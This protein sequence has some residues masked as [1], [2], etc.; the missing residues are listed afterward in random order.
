MT[1]AE[2]MIT[3][4]EEYNSH[5]AIKV[6]GVGGGGNNAINRMI[7]DN[8]AGVEFIAANTDAQALR[9]SRAPMKLQLGSNLTKGLGA[10]SNPDR[11]RDAALEDEDRIREI[12]GGSDMVFITAGMGGGTGTGG[13][14]VIARIARDMGALTV[15]VVTRP[16]DFEGKIRKRQAERGIEEL[17]E[18]VDTLITIPNQRLLE[19]V[20]KRESLVSAFR[21]ADEVLRNAVQGISDLIT[22]PGLINLDFADVRTVMANMGIALMG[23]GIAEGENRAVN[24]A[25]AAIR[26]P[27]LEDTTVDGA[28][29]ILINISAASDLTLMEVSEASE[30][31]EDAADE[32][33]HIIFGAVLDDSLGPA[34]KV[35]VI[36]T[37][38][39]Q[40]RSS[41]QSLASPAQKQRGASRRAAAA[42]PATQAQ[43]QPEP[44]AAEPAARGTEPPRRPVVEI[45]DYVKPR[46]GAEP[47]RPAAARLKKTA[48]GGMAGIESTEPDYQN[49]EIPTFLRRSYD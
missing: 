20:E 41:T 1:R 22:V 21:K 19:I 39:D 7:E 6:I 28:K 48:E 9:S 14:P 24:A 35:T 8:I 26:S 27:L 44:V 45:G 36:A 2:D 30:I 33:A 23:T 3:F 34:M 15:A 32:E 29:G 40:Q 10:G 37:G 43:P 12:L 46:P 5:A 25:T 4:E 11:G 13:A 38:F 49:L 42:A 18:S 31:I 16:F 47:P 17:R